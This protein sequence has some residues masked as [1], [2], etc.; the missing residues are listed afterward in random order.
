M[1]NIAK[2]IATIQKL[3]VESNEAKAMIDDA[4][5]NNSE[6]RELVDAK[7]N[8]TRECSIVKEQI[9]NEPGNVELEKKLKDLRQEISEEKEML[10]QE[11]AVHLAKE[12]K[13][14]ITLPDGTTYT[15]KLSATLSAK[16]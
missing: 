8:A 16:N 13:S 14:E 7:K 5:E 11:L 10:S 2:Y 9:L 15:F 4:L 3:K 12:G 6:Y 1:S